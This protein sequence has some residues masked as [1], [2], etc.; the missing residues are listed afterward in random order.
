MVPGQESVEAVRFPEWVSVKKNCNL[1]VSQT[2]IWDFFRR[3]ESFVS[4][5]VTD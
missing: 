3:T 4:G 1:D 2:I 5:L